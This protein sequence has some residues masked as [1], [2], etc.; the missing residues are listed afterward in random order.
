MIK[1][2]IVII[3]LIVLDIIWLNINAKQY[4]KMIKSIQNKEIKINI[5]YALFTYVLMIASII[6]INIPFIESKITKTDSKT[7]IIKKSLLYSGLLGLF[8]YN[9]TNL[10]TLENY[11]IGLGLKDTLWGFILYTIV[12]TTYFFNFL[13]IEIS[14]YHLFQLNY[15]T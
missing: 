14:Y 4:S 15:H 8:I 13:I 2:I 11:D 6:F 12:T 3:L 9:G 10:A 5:T 1:Y 7:E